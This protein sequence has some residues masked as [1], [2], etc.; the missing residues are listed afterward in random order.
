[1]YNL[2]LKKKE[3]CPVFKPKRLEMKNG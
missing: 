1:M 3:K 2:D